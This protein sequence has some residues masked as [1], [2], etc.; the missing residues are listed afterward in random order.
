M[1]I[2]KKLVLC[3]LDGCGISPE[4]TNNGLSE[5]VN[6]DRLTQQYPSATIQASEQFVGLPKG[7]M[8]NSEVGHMSIG[9]GRLIMQD[10]PRID[11]AIQNGDLE[12]NPKVRTLIEKIKATG[13]ACHLL[14]LLSPG[15]VHSHQDHLFAIARFLATKEIPVKIH[16]FLD[17]RDTPPQSA[18]DY[19]AELQELTNAVATI[20]GRYFAMDRDKRWERVLPAYDAMVLGKSPHHFSTPE[21]AIKFFYDTGITDEFIPSSLIG[22]YSG[23]NDGDALWMINFRADRARQILTSLLCDDFGEFKRERIVQFSATLGMAEYAASLTPL[24]PSVFD[25]VPLC[26]GLGEIIAQHG[27]CQLRL[28][29]TEKYAHVTFFFNGGRE[30]PFDGEDRILIPS[31][32]VATYDLCPPMSADKVTE[33]LLKAMND[34][35]HQLIVVNYANLDMVG[36]TG[37]QPAIMGAAHTIDSI[38]AILEETA[39]AKDWTLIVTADHGNAEQMVDELGRPHTAHTC[40]PVPFIIIN[41]PHKISLTAGGTLCDIAPTVLTLLDLPIPPEMDGRSLVVMA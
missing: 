13:G 9:L 34:S 33:Q 6:L 38:L 11:Q 24:I 36:H 17:G 31:P 10:L 7:Q 22:L 19:C 41:A 39:L 3:I 12:T 25:K 26:N 28:A 15:G 2:T 8:G 16:V 21:S 1:T 4:K 32:K 23:M 27:G 37:I 5:A 29:E 20:G 40:N 30:L 14:A 35:E 18:L